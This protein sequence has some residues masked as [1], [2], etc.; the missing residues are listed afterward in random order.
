MLP[1]SRIQSDPYAIPKFEMTSEDINRFMTELKTFHQCFKDCFARCETH[2]S[3]F[4]YMIGQFSKLERKS[5]EPIAIQT[6]DSKQNRTLSSKIRAM[7]RSISDAQ[8]DE[9]KI[10]HKYRCMI[11]EDLAHPEAA[12][13][14]DESGFIKKGNDSI[15]VAR[16]YCGTAGKVDNCQVGVFAAY[17]SPNGYSLIDKRLFIPEKWFNSEY[18]ER[19]IK[20]KLPEDIQ[21]KSK[22]QLAADM[23]RHIIAEA[24]LPFR[25][26]MADSLYGNSPDFIQAVCEYPEL[27]YMVAIPSDTLC[28]TQEPVRVERTY[29]YG[30]KQRVREILEAGTDHPVSI[31]HLA[32][33]IHSYF[34][35]KRTVS[36]GAKG[37]I[38]YEFTR[39]R[40]TIARHGL[41]NESV[42]L[43]IRRPWKQTGEYSYYISNAPEDTRLSVFVWLSGMRW[44]IEQCFEEVK[45]ELGMDQYELRK[46]PGWHHHILSC[47]LGHFFLWHMKIKLEKKSS[48]SYSIPNQMV[49]A[50]Y[51][52]DSKIHSERIA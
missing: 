1:V 42:W 46:F 32:E 2:E 28:W 3:L 50:D 19:R 41:P 6:K 43:I 44:P 18:K 12:M 49:T 38:D 31:K 11:N 5:I 9:E 10:L 52:S 39:K 7:Q 36:E 30:G 51:P 16:Q 27:I 20:C 22:P 33:T 37:P 15:G 45:S 25:Y 26:V 14:F 40:I 8:W 24:T 34:W 48:C 21:W 4:E 47:M 23:L 29:R 35:Y 17:A 13:I